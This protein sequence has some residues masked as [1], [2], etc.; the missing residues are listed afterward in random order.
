M[1]WKKEKNNGGLFNE[2]YE[3]I[4]DNCNREI[5][6]MIKDYKKSGD[7]N[8]LLHLDSKILDVKLKANNKI[9]DLFASML[10]NFS[11]PLYTEDTIQET[12]SNIEYTRKK[13]EAMH[14]RDREMANLM[15]YGNKD[16][17]EKDKYSNKQ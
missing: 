6:D 9:S 11:A 4:M 10:N 5:R 17:P 2:S 12:S 15:I 13:L 7:I 16:G 14:Q 3:K 1:F 8:D